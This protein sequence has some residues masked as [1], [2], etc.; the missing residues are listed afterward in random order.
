MM[1]AL[2]LIPTPHYVDYKEGETLSISKVYVC[3][4]VGNSVD[5]A[6]ELL[7]KKT[8]FIISEKSEA[9]VLITLNPEKHFSKE[10]LGVFNEKYGETQGYLLKKEKNSP[11]II[12]ARSPV[13]C[14]YGIMTLI[15]LLGKDVSE[16]IIRDRPDFKQRGNKWQVWAESG[17]WSYDYGDGA[18]AIKQRFLQK[19]EMNALR[20]INVIYADSFG[21]DAD[22]FPEYADILR[23][24]NDRARELGISLYTG[25]YGMSYGQ[26]AFGNT[27]H[28]KNY[29]N[30]KSYPDGEVYE[31]I[32]TY[33]AYDID[34]DTETTDYSH[35]LDKVYAREHGTCLSNEAL[36][37]LKIDEMKDYITKT[38]CGGLYLHNMD[39]HEIHPELWKARCN[40]C[41][42]KWPNDDLF[43]K[44]GCAGAFAEYFDTIANELSQIKDG[45][46]DASK[47]LKIMV[48]SPGYLYPV[49]TNDEDF[50]TGVDFWKA[51]S[52][53][54]KSDVIAIGFREHF[55]YHDKDVRRAEKI[56][57]SK[58]KHDTIIINF[59]GGDGFYDDKIFT[60]T[61]AVNYIMKGFDGMLC[62]NGNGFQEPLQLF[63]AEYLWNSERSAYFNI[64]DKPKNQKE[65]L[66]LYRSAIKSDF[67]PEEIYGDNG[68]LDVI[69]EKIYGEKIA[70]KMAQI[71]KL[72]GK[73]GEPPILCASSVDIYTNFSKMIFPMR[74]D[75]AD[76]TPEKIDEMTGRFLECSKTS[77]KAEEIMSQTSK[78]FNGDKAIKTDLEWLFDCAQMGKKLTGLFYEYMLIYTEL[79]KAF[80]GGEDFRDGIIDDIN[81]LKVKIKDYNNWID[82]SSRKPIDKLGGGLVRRKNMGDMLDYWTSLMISSINTNKRIPDDAKPLPVK[83]WW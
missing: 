38:H 83:R 2:K 15:D 41:R 67:R 37:M 10:D 80:S 28:G 48:V 58:F 45:E 55:F 81:A 71:Y 23:T 31:C 21:L 26:A 53:Y 4:C 25:C 79:D 36:T 12:A 74:W 75:N 9:D 56:I 32:G 61:A 11:I 33:D 59:S 18:E 54:L 82:S 62:A 27:F 76:I 65:F 51:V 39:A 78:T 20:K 72:C 60:P 19:I 3:K 8:D 5:T 46:Y 30:C 22:R 43:A 49:V 64:E 29:L 66:K 68:F 24:A 69:C 44:D 7:A 17:I 50:N 35:R 40:S 1:K 47:H 42:K 14:V 34:F 73:N 6:L 63:N 77:A 52:E 70:S 16:I 57:E 13:G